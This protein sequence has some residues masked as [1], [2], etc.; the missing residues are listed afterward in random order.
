MNVKNT[1]NWLD[2]LDRSLIPKATGM[3]INKTAT[4]VKSAAS[5]L[6]AKQ[7]GTTQKVVNSKARLSKSSRVRD[8]AVITYSGKP[9][10]LVRFGARQTKKGISAAPWGNRRVFPGTFYGNDRRTVFKRQTKARL[11]I[12]SVYGPSIPQEAAREA[13]GKASQQ[14]VNIRFPVHFRAALNRLTSRRSR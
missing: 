9:L 11:P 2:K 6:I 7:M 13:V 4:N 10:N 12:K 8:F 14:V 1:V 3:A 5:K